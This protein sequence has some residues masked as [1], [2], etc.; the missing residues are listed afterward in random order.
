MFHQDLSHR[1]H[2]PESKNLK[3]TVPSHKKHRFDAAQGIRTRPAVA[4]DRVAL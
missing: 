4:W 1:S 3:I 2:A